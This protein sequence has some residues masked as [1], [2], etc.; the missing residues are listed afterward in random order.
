MNVFSYL[1]ILLK[2]GSMSFHYMDTHKVLTF[3]LPLDIFS[4]ISTIILFYLDGLFFNLLYIGS[5]HFFLLCLFLC[6]F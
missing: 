3:A 4:L 6:I 2:Y 5:A 1:Y